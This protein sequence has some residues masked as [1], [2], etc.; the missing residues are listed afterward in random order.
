[1][2]N[3]YTPIGFPD[4]E[5][6]HDVWKMLTESGKELLWLENFR[7]MLYRDPSGLE[8]WMN[9]D[10][11]GNTIC[12]EPYFYGSTH[13]VRL[14]EIRANPWEDGTGYAQAW[15]GGDG[16][17][18]GYPF[19]FEIPVFAYCRPEWAGSSRQ[20]R[21]A[22][23]A[24]SLEC[25]ADEAAYE[26]ANSDEAPMFAAAQ[27]FI[28][29]GMFRDDLD[30]GKRASAHARISGIVRTAETRTNTVSGC[31]FY[32]CTIESYG[33]TWAAVIPPE[34]LPEPPQAGNVLT[35]IFWLTGIP[36]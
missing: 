30:E 35:G 24:E 28:P 18:D 5:D 16:E 23:F 31:P 22:A 15:H 8:I 9:Q 19:I 6:G 26:A 29:V 21:L 10:E 32:H 14:D 1:M 13:T 7:S 34:L 25:Y 17:E 11:D 12:A 36:E 3:H 33:G 27:S 2:I 20:V 4:A